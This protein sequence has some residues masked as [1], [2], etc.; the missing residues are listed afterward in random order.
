MPTIMGGD[1]QPRRP[2]PATTA[3]SS[4][5]Q[6]RTHRI[7]QSAGAGRPIKRACGCDGFAVSAFGFRLRRWGVS[8]RAGTCWAV[9]GFGGSG[10]RGS[11]R[12]RVRW[13][14]AMENGTGETGDWMML[15]ESDADL[16]SYLRNR[17]GHGGTKRNKT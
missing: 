4:H 5:T 15:T 16:N 3:R 11:R 8:G 1:T 10:V 17:T 2:N 6:P 7:G 13:S 14:Y 9:R 12:R